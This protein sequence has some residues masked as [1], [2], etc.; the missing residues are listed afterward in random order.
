[1][2]EIPND[3]LANLLRYLPLLIDNLDQQKVRKSLRLTNAVRVTKHSIIPKLK[4]IDNEQKNRN[5]EE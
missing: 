2:R 1:M 5:R 4:K 3:I